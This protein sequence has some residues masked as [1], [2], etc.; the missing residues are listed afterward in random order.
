MFSQGCVAVQWLK[1]EKQLLPVELCPHRSFHT[2]LI[3]PERVGGKMWKN[4]QIKEKNQRKI[5]TTGAA[6]VAFIAGLAGCALHSEQLAAQPQDP[7]FWCWWWYIYYDEVSVCLFV[8]NEKSSL[9]PGSFLWLP[10]LPITTLYNSGLVLMVLDWF[11]M[12]PFRF[13]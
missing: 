13:L 3:V 1:N 10:E 6:T 5:L 12:V 4:I 8:C 9:P 2:K 7:I 11:F